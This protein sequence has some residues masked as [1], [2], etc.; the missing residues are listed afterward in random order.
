MAVQDALTLIFTRNVF[1]RRLYHLA[2]ATFALFIIIIA[3]LSGLLF[4]IV[5]NPSQPI[6]FATDAIS[7]LMKF[8]PL[9]RP[10]MSAEDVGKWAAE[11]V[12]AAYSYDYV[13]YRSELQNAQKYFTN[14]GWRN[15]MKALQASNNLVALTQRQM[16]VRAKI[17]E[18]PKLTKQGVLSGRYAYRF[19]MPVL[20][21]YLLPPYD[22]N[23]RFSN[24]LNVTVL[25]RREPVLQ[26]Y[27]GLGVLQMIGTA[28]S[29]GGG[30]VPQEIGRTPGSQ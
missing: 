16:I 5:S 10:N 22:A 19:E 12:E 2:L 1:Y 15:Y 28:A 13:N 20:V 27:Q 18:T 3:C 24:A 26:S 6:Y 29:A 7:R 4:Y 14:Y 9:D 21:T 8:V 11:S 23:S 30:Q 17:I 25:L